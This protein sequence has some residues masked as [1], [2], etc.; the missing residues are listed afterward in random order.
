MVKAYCRELVNNV[1]YD[2]QQ[3]LVGFGYVRESAIELMVRD[4]RIHAGGG[5]ATKVMLD[6]VAKRI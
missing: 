5:G 2:W 3:F 6:E 1:M 4:A